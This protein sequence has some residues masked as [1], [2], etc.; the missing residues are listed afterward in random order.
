LVLNKRNIFKMK[1]SI[2]KLELFKSSSKPQKVRLLMLALFAVGTAVSSLIAISTTLSENTDNNLSKIAGTFSILAI[3]GISVFV[4]TASI[5]R[6]SIIDS[7]TGIVGSAISTFFALF[8]LDALFSWG[9]AEKLFG[10][11]DVN[12]FISLPAAGELKTLAILWVVG[13]F[14][15]GF[16]LI[17]TSKFISRIMKGINVLI[18]SIFASYA[19]YL[20]MN[21]DNG[22]VARENMKL[23]ICVVF[24]MLAA[25]AGALALHLAGGRK[26]TRRRVKK[27]DEPNV[28]VAPEANNDMGIS[29]E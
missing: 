3:L 16:A 24:L 9:F 1:K 29:I 25:N 7:L 23:F 4:Q 21:Y 2:S 22:S 19:I 17:R 27:N 6:K 12:S 28:T 11:G 20:I 26:P 13:W 10:K 5:H 18:N 14:A 8:S 15:V